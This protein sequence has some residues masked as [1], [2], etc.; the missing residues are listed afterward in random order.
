MKESNST[1][2]LTNTYSNLNAI[3]LSDQ[4]KFR[5]DETSK[6]KEYFTEEMTMSF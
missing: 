5:L 4:R 6:I 2:T 3:P 1:E